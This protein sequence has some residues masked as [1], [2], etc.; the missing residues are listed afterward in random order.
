MRA[1]VTCPSGEATYPSRRVSFLGLEAIA[2]WRMKVYGLTTEDREPRKDL[3]RAA[4]AMVR[5]T[6]PPR[7]AACAPTDGYGFCIIHESVRLCY[8]LVQW[9]AESNEMHQRLFST[10]VT[11]DEPLARHG[12]PAIGCVWELG[13]TDHERRAWTAHVLARAT[14][15]DF[16]A[17]LTSTISGRY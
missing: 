14:D 6:L 17:Y 5:A 9:W 16:D 3:V 11:G 4:L 7:S 12:S 2:G 13:V 1:E 15:P 10:P 8:V